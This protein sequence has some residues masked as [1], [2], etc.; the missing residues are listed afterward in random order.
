MTQKEKE[1][2]LEEKYLN[3]VIKVYHPGNGVELT[4][5]VDRISVWD[6]QVQ[7]TFNNNIMHKMDIDYFTDENVIIYGTNGAT[8]G[9]DNIFFR[10]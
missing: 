7:F 3:K 4:G 5:K 8:G 2:Q 6:G 1:L 10:V 9:D